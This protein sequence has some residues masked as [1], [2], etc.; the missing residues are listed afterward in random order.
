[1]PSK[2]S[3]MEKVS[4]KCLLYRWL[5]LTWCVHIYIYIYIYVPVSVLLL[6]YFIMF[7][8]QKIHQNA[9]TLPNKF[10][11]TTAMDFQ[12]LKVK[13]KDICLTKNYCTTIGIQK[14]NSFH[15]FIFKI[16]QILGSHELKGHG[17]FWPC[18][19]AKHW[20]NF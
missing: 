7:I 19:S 20:T 4:F 5:P 13:E 15:K 3:C 9:I 18:P 1:M 17:H 8:T 6:Y 12:H 16:H 14:I 11:C 10:N 2:F